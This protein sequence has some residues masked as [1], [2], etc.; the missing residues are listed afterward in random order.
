MFEQ[1]H[2]SVLLTCP[3]YY[4]LG[5]V[6]C[7]PSTGQPNLDDRKHERR[8]GL[9]DLIVYLPMIGR[10]RVMEGFSGAIEICRSSIEYCRDWRGNIILW[11]NSDIFTRRLQDTRPVI[12]S[13]YECCGLIA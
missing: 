7:L 6:A 3:P 4:C 9:R 11:K 2:D 12:A 13:I 5:D 1:R 10:H 8:A